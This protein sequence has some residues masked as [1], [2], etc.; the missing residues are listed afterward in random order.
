M[1]CLIAIPTRGRHEKLGLL[2]DQIE[3]TRQGDSHF[4]IL[5]DTDDPGPPIRK[6][7]WITVTSRPRDWLTPKLNRALLPVAKQGYYAAVG[8]LA[9]DAWPETPGWDA[10]LMAALEEEP[11]IAWPD[12]DRRP[13]FPEHQIVSSRIV[14]AL[15]WY[16]EP[17]LRHYWTDDVWA[18][19]ATAAGCGRYVR[20]AM[21]RHDH[22]SV[23]GGSRERSG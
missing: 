5:A 19:L 3:A 9:D 14:R 7:P 18:D 22:Y 11:G 20:G 8:W 12:S 16:F 10:L 1:R 15:G 4:L 6:R 23:T 17:T 2:L 13:G 21:V